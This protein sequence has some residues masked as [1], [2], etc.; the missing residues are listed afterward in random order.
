MSDC[1][2]SDEDIPFTTEP[3]GNLYKPEYIDTVLRQME[4]EWAE[5]EERDRKAFQ[6]EVGPATVAVMRDRVSDKWWCTCSKCVKE[7]NC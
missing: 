3:K 4:L 2:T 5:R 6:A 7:R 1:E